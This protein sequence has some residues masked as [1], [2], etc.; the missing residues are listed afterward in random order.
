M[1]ALNKLFSPKWYMCLDFLESVCVFEGKDYA[2]HFF[3]V[4]QCLA[5]M[6]IE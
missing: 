4:T 3:G 2:L 1:L 5:K 6:A